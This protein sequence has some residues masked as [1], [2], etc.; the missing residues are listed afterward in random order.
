MNNHE[1]P[2]H[3][4]EQVFFVYLRV[5]EEIQKAFNIREGE[6]FLTKSYDKLFKDEFSRLRSELSRIMKTSDNRSKDSHKLAA[7]A[8]LSVLLTKPLEVDTNGDGHFLNEVMAYVLAV[9][10]IQLYQMHRFCDTDEQRANLK[11][12]IGFIATPALIYEQTPVNNN[13]IFALK[14]FSRVLNN[15]GS[16]ASDLLLLLSSFM[17]YIDA[18]SQDTVKSMAQAIK[19]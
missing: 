2:K 12:N 14:Y 10:I 5:F 8:C 16:Y 1:I 19:R 3:L 4:E 18:T 17:F 11:K 6:V 7:I 9:R 13:T 15:I